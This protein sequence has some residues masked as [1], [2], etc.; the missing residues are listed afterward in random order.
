MR[1]RRTARRKY[2]RFSDGS[3]LRRCRD[4]AVPRRPGRGVRSELHP[5]HG[6]AA[7]ATRV[8]GRAASATGAEAGFLDCA[9]RLIHPSPRAFRKSGELG[10]SP[11]SRR[12]SRCPVLA[13][14][15]MTR[16]PAGKTFRLTRHIIQYR[17]HR[18]KTA[19]QTARIERIIGRWRRG[20]G[21]RG[22][23]KRLTR[24]SSKDL[25]RGMCA[26]SLTCGGRR[27]V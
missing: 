13:L 14:S 23:W 7:G 2:L 10:G 5:Q 11:R 18:F 20:S 25:M 22:C 9:A 16:L 3:A 15:L 12:A 8:G 21:A 19:M 4:A 26:V 6:R 27:T 24:G 1:R 17:G